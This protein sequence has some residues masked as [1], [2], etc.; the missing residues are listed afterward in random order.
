MISLNG[1][2]GNH[3]Q[4]S[5][6]SLATLPT[7]FG[8]P[9]RYPVVYVLLLPNRPFAEMFMRCGVPQTHAESAIEAAVDAFR[10]AASMAVHD[11]LAHVLKEGSLESH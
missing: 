5:Q 8:N 10:T 9:G 2:T 11:G 3:N 1:P 7:Y 6:D 4:V